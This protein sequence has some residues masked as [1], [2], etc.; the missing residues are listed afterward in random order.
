MYTCTYYIYTS[1]SLDIICI[2]CI[3]IYIYIERERVFRQGSR[4]TASFPE[5]RSGSM[6]TGRKGDLTFEGSASRVGAKPS[7]IVRRT[8]RRASLGASQLLCH[9]ELS[10]CL[11]PHLGNPF[12]WTMEINRSLG[13]KPAY[14]R[15]CCLS[16]RHNYNRGHTE[17]PHPRSRIQ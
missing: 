1:L 3:Y 4:C 16:T 11:P 12:F 15:A 8:T 5:V 13:R 2:M 9:L 14:W 6:W 17:R 10:S 7:L